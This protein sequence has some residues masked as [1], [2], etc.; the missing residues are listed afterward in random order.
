M[1]RLTSIVAVNKEGA[2]GA[3][4][5]LPWRIK[6]DTMFFK[7]QTINNVVIMG[8]KTFELS[9]KCLP[10]R[11]NIVVSSNQALFDRITESTVAGCVE[12]ALYKAE[13]ASRRYREIFVA[14]GASTYS[15]FAPFVDRHLVTLVDKTIEDADTF[16]DDSVFGSL[17]D[18]N[19]RLL[20]RGQANNIGD[21]AAYEILELTTKDETRRRR[22]RAQAIDAWGEFIERRQRLEEREKAFEEEPARVLID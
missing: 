21:E 15:L 10:S 7:A 22:W 11:Y 1:R 14:G 12:E 8:R 4:T 13:E 17:D 19:I 2:I 6:S 3:G 18:W 5:A 16:L 20:G 9:E